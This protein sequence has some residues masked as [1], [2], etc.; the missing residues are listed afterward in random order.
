MSV[1]PSVDPSSVLLVT[2]DSCR[3][4]TFASATAPALAAVGPLHEAQAPSHFTLAS[5]AAMFAGFTP[6][7]AGAGVPFVE[8]KRGRLFR[9]AG[10]AFPTPPSAG[11]FAL[12]GRTIVAGFRR[13]GYAAFGTGAVGWFDPATPAARLL[14]DD[15]EEFFYPGDS[16]SLRRQL[17]WLD[18]RLRAAGPRPVFAFLNVGE[19]HVPYFHEGA[20]WDAGDNPCVPFQEVDRSADCRVRQRRCLEF[21][22]ALLAPLLERFAAATVV[23]C[24]D[25]GDCWGEDGLWEHGVSHPM[26]L[27]VPLLLR[28]RGA[29]VAAPEPALVTRTVGW[30]AVPAGPVER[31]LRS[32]EGFTSLA[33]CRLLYDLARRVERGCIVEVGAYRGRSTVALGRG[34]L[35]G[36]RVPVF[37]LEPHAPFTGVLGARF[38]PADAGAFHRAMAATGCYHVVRLLALTSAEVAPGWRHPVELLWIDGDHRYAAVRRDF[39][40]WRPHLQPGAVV[41]LDDAADPALGPHRLVAELAAEGVAG[42]VERHGKLALFRVG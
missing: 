23:A 37:T 34:S 21:V 38:G 25:H 41:V 26:T 8:P 30:D 3:Y 35:D 17:A 18:E 27:T 24:G 2:L 9:L 7:V 10:P 6:G 15:F 12:E 32:V 19:T 11:S 40:L 5:H 28:V 13:L 1:D 42:A 39:E 16:W 36:H 33:E 4:D 31:F 29:P 20:E 14:V 22:D